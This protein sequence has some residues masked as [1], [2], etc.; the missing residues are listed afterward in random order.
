MER[1]LDLHLGASDNFPS[2]IST[3]W[4]SS[5]LEYLYWKSHASNC[6]RSIYSPCCTL[7]QIEAGTWAGGRLA[8]KASCWWPV[9]GT[10]CGDPGL[11]GAVQGGCV[12]MPGKGGGL[13]CSGAMEAAAM[14]REVQCSGAV[15]WKAGQGY[16]ASWSID[17]SPGGA[18]L[19]CGQEGRERLREVA[20]AL[21]N[22]STAVSSSGWGFLAGVPC[23]DAWAVGGCCRSSWWTSSVSWLSC[24]LIAWFSWVMCISWA[25][26]SLSSDGSISSEAMTPSACCQQNL[27]SL[28]ICFP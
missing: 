11:S 14:S 8:M 3:I 16:T 6:E 2:T 5:N 12:C 23:C 25:W 18:S 10:A 20:G 4:Q 26:T 1:C 24:A 9:P 17:G 27:H 22:C 19:C 15:V 7:L 21:G 28:L 13:S